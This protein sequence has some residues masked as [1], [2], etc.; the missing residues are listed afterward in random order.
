MV[1]Q[2]IDFAPTTKQFK[3]L[4]YLWDNS[5]TEILY[6]GSVSSGKSR[7]AC[8]WLIL[9]CLKY[10]GTRYLLGRARLLNL[11]RTTLK[12]FLDISRE[13]GIEHLY[14]FNRQDNVIKFNNGSEII[15]MDLFQY[16]SDEEFVKLGSLE[17]TAAVIDEGGEVSEKAYRILKT[18]LRYKLKEY[19]L[20]PKLFIC[21]NPSK[22]WL[23][24]IFY[25][26]FKDNE[27]PDYR[28]FIQALPSDNQYNSKEYLK[29]LTPENLGSNIYQMLVLG[30]WDYANTDYDLFE[31]NSLVNSFY[32]QSPKQSLQRY[33]TI[34]PAS[35]GKDSTVITYWIGYDC[36]QILNL[37]K[38][39]TSQIVSQ[40]RNMMTVNNVPIRNVIV[41]RVG[42]GVGV[43][44]GL[45]GC[46]G[47]VA[48]AVP[49]GK[50]P[51]SNLKSQCFYKFAELV[52]TGNIGFINQIDKLDEV[53]IQLE[54]HKR[55]NAGMDK[56]AEVTPKPIVKQMLGKSP[57]IADALSMRAYFEFSSGAVTRIVGGR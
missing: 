4:E 25:K 57:D 39:D 49:F 22:N 23:Y 13:W 2:Q 52:N 9:S 56:K 17:I 16:P 27:L 24:N 21:S 37:E 38:N 30:D 34:D 29:S 1:T 53:S 41:D 45:K 14:D 36:V 20:V 31:H 46:Q 44:D 18:R 19:G 10:P 55:H 5:T 48:N 32:H 40:V 33:I 11:K 3:A 26:P 12:T 42:I 35:M 51:F 47:F 54:A 28:R 43:F 8:Y 6:G 7:L 50:E 15:L